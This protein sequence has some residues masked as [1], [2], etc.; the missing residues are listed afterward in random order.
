[1]VALTRRSFLESAGAS[2]F[3]LSNPNLGFTESKLK[4]NGLATRINGHISTPSAPMPDTFKM[5]ISGWIRVPSN[6]NATANSN[7]LFAATIFQYG[8]SQFNFNG[9]FPSDLLVAINF[10]PN[11]AA[12]EFGTGNGQGVQY[13]GVDQ[14]GNPVHRGTPG[15]ADSAIYTPGT[16]SYDKWYLLQ[17]SYDFSILSNYQTPGS[18]LILPAAKIV[19]A[20]SG[21]VSPPPVQSG[22]GTIGFPDN[23]PQ[24]WTQDTLVPIAVSGWPMGVPWVAQSDKPPVGDI[25]PVDIYEFMVWSGVFLDLN[26]QGN[27]F[28]T[29]NNRGGI[30]PA[31]LGTAVKAL[32]PPDLYFTG[33]PDTFAMNKGTAG[34]FMS[35]NGT[36]SS[37]PRPSN[38]P[39]VF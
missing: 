22:W 3:T 36:L 21:K 29:R 8:S 16:L 39:I 26:A 27:L 24:I 25:G 33:P 18:V 20:I 38:A 7:G 32:G 11:N 6:P 1:M 4:L 23:P 30:D 19:A 37:V 35:L 2:V 9:N 14:F 15:L 31:P 13:D 5:L 10:P 28:Y 12:A 34:D 17:A